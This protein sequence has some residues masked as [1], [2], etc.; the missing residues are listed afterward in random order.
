MFGAMQL[1]PEQEKESPQNQGS[2]ES[3]ATKFC[4][5]LLF[6]I[7]YSQPL[8]IEVGHPQHD[9]IGLGWM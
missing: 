8:D 6:P 3:K 2:I 7:K 1:H 4:W 5:S 9:L